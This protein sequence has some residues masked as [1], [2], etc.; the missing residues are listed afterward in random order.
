MS[1]GNAARKSSDIDVCS[2]G[3]VCVWSSGV[4]ADG[5]ERPKL[6]W[7]SFMFPDDLEGGR[8]RRLLAGMVAEAGRECPEDDDL[9]AGPGSAGSVGFDGGL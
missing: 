4:A 1:S 7:V 2:G 5:R 9:A 6:D 3:G 8:P